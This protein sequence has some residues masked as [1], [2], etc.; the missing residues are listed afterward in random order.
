MFKSRNELVQPLVIRYKKF[1]EDSSSTAKIF[2]LVN[3]E[4]CG[5]SHSK[6]GASLASDQRLLIAL[7]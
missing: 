3:R 2:K 7:A 6:D 1:R 4:M 5:T